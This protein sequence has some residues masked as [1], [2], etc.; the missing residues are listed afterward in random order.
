MALVSIPPDTLVLLDSFVDLL[1]AWQA[2]MNLVGPSTLAH[3][4]TR[5]IADSFQLL[6]HAPDAKVWVDLGSGAGFPGLVL[7]CALKDKPQA[8]VHLI[9]STGK[10]ANFLRE[11][12][13]RLDLP[14]EVHAAR[15]EDVVK[16]LRSVDIVTAR[17]L[18]PLTS[19]LSYAQPLLQKGAQALFPKGQDV[20]AELTQAA[21]SWNIAVDKFPSVTDPRG[22]ILRIQTS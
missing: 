21:K 13:H 1:L 10:K 3:V 8:H 6:A 14:A 11:V 9:E 18:A 2:R 12:A 17:A 5:H 4:W 22:R 7:A 20:D 16:G 19:L 15:I